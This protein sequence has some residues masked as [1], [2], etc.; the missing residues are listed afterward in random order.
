LVIATHPLRCGSLLAISI[1][2]RD[3]FTDL[4]R[5]FSSRDEEGVRMT[6]YVERRG[7]FVRYEVRECGIGDGWELFL[8]EHREDEDINGPYEQLIQDDAWP[9]EQRGIRS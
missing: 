6:C 5:G 2:A 1:G 7:G 3:R 9:S 8:S 4:G